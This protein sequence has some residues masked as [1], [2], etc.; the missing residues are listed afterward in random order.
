MQTPVPVEADEVALIPPEPAMEPPPVDDDVPLPPTS[1]GKSPVAPFAQDIQSM[2]AS[3]SEARPQRLSKRTIL[4]LLSG[5]KQ[6]PR[7][8]H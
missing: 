5:R 6:T 3:A 2:L 7:P 1:P 4:I 8:G